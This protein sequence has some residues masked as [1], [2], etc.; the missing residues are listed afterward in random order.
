MR[1]PITCGVA[2][3]FMRCTYASM[4]MYT[5]EKEELHIDRELCERTV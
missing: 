2:L 5:V 4:N 3:L 1:P